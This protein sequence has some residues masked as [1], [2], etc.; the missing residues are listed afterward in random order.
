MLH[1]EAARQMLSGGD[2][3]PSPSA[4][5]MDDGL[6]TLT[7]VFGELGDRAALWESCGIRAIGWAERCYQ[8]SVSLPW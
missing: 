3:A 5:L 4:Y 7:A 8:A 2:G 1:A 6:G